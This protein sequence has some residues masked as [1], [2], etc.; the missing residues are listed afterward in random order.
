M[1]IGRPG[2]GVFDENIKVTVVFEHAGVQQLVLRLL[3]PRRRLP[4]Q[5]CHRVGVLRYLHRYFMY[6]WVGVLSR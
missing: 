6:E 1:N 2:L 4:R 5:D 3:R